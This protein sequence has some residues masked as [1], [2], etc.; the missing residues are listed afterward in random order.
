MDDNLVDWV[1]K[2]EKIEENSTVLIWKEKKIVT[3]IS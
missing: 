3:L 1:G 2:L